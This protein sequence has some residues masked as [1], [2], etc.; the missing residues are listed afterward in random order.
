[1]TRHTGHDE[2]FVARL[3]EEVGRP[4]S[5][6]A[7]HLAWEFL[8]ALRTVP[9]VDDMPEPIVMDAISIVVAKMAAHIDQGK[10]PLALG[11]ALHQIETIALDTTREHARK[12]TEAMIQHLTEQF[13]A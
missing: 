5:P 6:Q 10:P 3:Y 2:A 12:Q 8:K 13:S 1:M 9:S 4:L 11:R 7:Q